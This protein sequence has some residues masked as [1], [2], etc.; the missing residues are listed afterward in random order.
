MCV[1][2]LAET[3]TGAR[4]LLE[5]PGLHQAAHILEEYGICSETDLSELDQHDFSELEFQ[6]M[7][8]R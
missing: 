1:N 3:D 8:W 4:A 6:K 7:T 2:T 5:K